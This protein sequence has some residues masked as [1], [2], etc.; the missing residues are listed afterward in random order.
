MPIPSIPPGAPGIPAS[1]LVGSNSGVIFG[2]SIAANMWANA[3]NPTMVRTSGIVTVTQTNQ[4]FMTGQFALVQGMSDTSF[5]GLQIVTRTGI[6]TYTF[7]S[8][9]PDASASG[10][11]VGCPY[12]QAD[13]GWFVW[14]R[15][16]LGNRLR[17]VYMA[18]IGGDTTGGML[19]RIDSDV[20]SKS[21]NWCSVMGGINDINALTAVQI[22]ANLK[23]IYTRLHAAGIIIIAH[24]ILPLESG[25]ANFNPTNQQKI[26]DVNALI[27]REASLPNTGIRLC[28]SFSVI[29]DPASAT[30]SPLSGM[31]SP[32]DHIHPSA[33]GGKCIGDLFADVLGPI[34]P[35]QN[36]LPSSAADNRSVNAANVNL[37]PGLPS[38]T[39]GGA[40][41]GTATGSPP[42]GYKVES[43]VGSPVVVAS[44]VARTKAADG[45]TNGTN[46]RMVFTATAANDVARM[47]SNGSGWISGLTIGKAYYLECA[48]KASDV[49][50]SNLS[51]LFAEANYVV[52]GV[53]YVAYFLQP[54][55][56]PFPDTDMIGVLQTTPFFITGTSITNIVIRLTA[57]ASAA[58]TAVTIDLGRVHV[59]ELPA[60]SVLG[61]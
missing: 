7:P 47:A 53:T 21:P 49:N 17:L 8:A 30:A 60:G 5:N 59:R 4:P 61:F 55:N 33:K 15:F 1:R 6:N 52:D 2:D 46:C 43:T 22:F 18:G 14:A 37:T 41:A 42:V 35:L 39:S 48:V 9:G 27:V 54:S 11:F 25:H 24:T 20:I 50:G 23:A 13:N 32:I 45:D 28:D 36:T 34:M 3:S 16:K 12:F 56:T 29:V 31:L 38:T 19:A 10:G 40:I 26:L 58:G 57:K 44:G 51:Q